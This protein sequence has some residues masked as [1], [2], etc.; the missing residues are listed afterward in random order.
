[1]RRGACKNGKQAA[2]VAKIIVNVPNSGGTGE[3]DKQYVEELL[4]RIDELV[5]G[6]SVQLSEE[7]LK[8]KLDTIIENINAKTSVDYNNVNSATNR[9]ITEYDSLKDT[10]KTQSNTISNQAAQIESQGVT[11]TNQA[12]EIIQL[13]ET[14]DTTKGQL[15]TTQGRLDEALKQIEALE[16][17]GLKAWDKDTEFTII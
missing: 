7:E 4:G 14:L 10:N 2:G 9:L 17:T 5:S 13:N 6:S 1:M 8:N 3:Y 11:I 15:N 12:N 16:S